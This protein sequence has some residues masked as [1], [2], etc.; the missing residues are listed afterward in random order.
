MSFYLQHYF[1]PDKNHLHLKPRAVNQ[2]HENLYD[3]GYVKNV[4]ANQVV[5]ELLPFESLDEPDN[6]DT[7]FIL[8]KARFPMGTNTHIDPQNPHKLLAS[9]N[10]YVFYNN[11]KITVKTVLNVRS[12]IN[13][14]TGNVHFVADAAIHG[15]VRAGFDVK[16]ENI[17]I[18]GMVEGGR[19]HAHKDLVI[20]GGAR[21]GAG[22]HCALTAGNTLR[23]AFTEKVD[24][25][26]GGNILIE[27]YSMHT[28]IYCSNNI[29]IQGRLLGGNTNSYSS[30]LVTE[31]VG[32]KAQVLT[33]I[34]LGYDPI[35]IRQLEEVDKRMAEMATTIK[36]LT[37]VAG[38]L[39]SDTN[40]TTQKLATL[41][42][43]QESLL[44]TR[45]D[46]WKKLYLDESN[47]T[48]CKLVVLGEIFPG[49]EVS[50]GRSFLF[51][52]ER[53]KNVVFS[54]VDDEIICQP[55]K[56]G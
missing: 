51:I 47:V 23:A 21:G 19:V 25:Q 38:H 54:L 22:H 45:N 14:Q 3:L 29:V 39:P 52:E 33:S 31:Q 46:L 15:N 7:R 44:N 16:A 9:S 48:R 40:D 30:V 43:R 10:G 42:I 18:T 28:N 6:A 17:L 1:N 27:K 20:R 11:G 12:D 34:F 53:Y 36:H 35:L 49:V 32:N 50:I 41:R 55:Y 8:E 56:K 26:A 24:V 2:N 37:A 4:L 13:F 5:A